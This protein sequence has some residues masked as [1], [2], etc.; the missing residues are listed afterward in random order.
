M[1]TAKY[2]LISA[3]YNTRTK[4]FR[5]NGWPILFILWSKRLWSIKMVRSQSRFPIQTWKQCWKSA[6][7][8]WKKVLYPQHIR[9]TAKLFLPLCAYNELSVYTKRFAK[10]KVDVWISVKLLQRKHRIHRVLEQKQKWS[11][12]V[13]GLVSP[14][15]FY[16][17]FQKA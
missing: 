12:S 2:G 16:S 8:V 14:K 9:T 17:L 10:K 5:Q 4:H 6:E 13:S 11:S 1:R 15:N 7:L 3:I